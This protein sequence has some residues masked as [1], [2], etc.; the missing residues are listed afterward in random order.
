MSLNFDDPKT[1]KL[2]LEVCSRYKVDPSSSL[3]AETFFRKLLSQYDKN[4]DPEKIV[5]WLE[6]QISHQFVAIGE[7]PRWMQGFDW[8]FVDKKPMIFAGQIDISVSDERGVASEIFHDNTSLYVFIRPK[9][10]S[11]VILQQS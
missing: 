11:V 10:S 5:V 7:R 2:L 4:S 6:E 1:Y 3:E 8:P 9:G